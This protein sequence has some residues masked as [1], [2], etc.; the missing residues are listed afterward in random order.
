[1]LFVDPPKFQALCVAEVDLQR[2]DA[3]PGTEG[4]LDLGA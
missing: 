1:M 3:F 2:D 4:R